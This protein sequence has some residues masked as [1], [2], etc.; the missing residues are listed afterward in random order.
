MSSV[1]YSKTA[2]KLFCFD[3]ARKHMQ[4]QTFYVIENVCHFHGPCISFRS[5]LVKNSNATMKR[6]ISFLLDG[7]YKNQPSA[8]LHVVSDLY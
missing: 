1:S 6:F 2:S 8:A 3:T 7:V 4:E 5:K